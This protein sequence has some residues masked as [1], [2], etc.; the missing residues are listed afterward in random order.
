MSKVLILAYKNYARIHSLEMLVGIDA[1]VCK[2]NVTLS[3]GV[4]KE[5]KTT[6]TGKCNIYKR[7]II[8]ICPKRRHELLNL[9][10]NAKS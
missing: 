1:I 3:T 6:V 5:K 4:F 8:S 7:R 2:M 10:I 9:S